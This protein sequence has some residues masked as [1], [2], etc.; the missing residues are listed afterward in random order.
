MA[1][2][3]GSGFDGK[4][5]LRSG[6]Y[7]TLIS[8]FAVAAVVVINLIVNSLPSNLTKPDTTS[9]DLYTLGE[10]TVSL[11]K[12]I[13]TDVKLYHLVQPNDDNLYV[14][15][16]SGL[17]ERYEGLSSRISVERVDPAL[18]P[19]FASAYTDDSVG[20][21][22]VIAV[23]SKRSKVV[24]LSD[25]YDVEQ[26]IDYSTYQY[27]QDVT[28]FKGENAISTAIDYVTTDVL[29][30]VYFLR[31]HN[32]VEMDESFLKYIDEEN[33]ARDTIS[34]IG[35]ES[36]PDDCDCIAVNAP[37]TDITE[38]EK[39]LL[40][41]WLSSGG[42]LMVMTSYGVDT[43]NLFALLRHYGAELAGGLVCDPTAYRYYQ[44]PY[45]LLPI[46][47]TS[48]EMTS[49][50]GQLTFFAPFCDGIV[51]TSDSRGEVDYRALLYTST[52]AYAKVSPK[53]TLEKEEGDVPGPC[54]VAVSMEEEVEN[55]TTKIVWIST[56]Q[57][58]TYNADVMCAGAN[59]ALFLNA[60]G[61]MCDKAS[62]ISIHSKTLSVDLLTVT[63]TSST[64]WGVVLIFLIPA[65]V[66]GIGV[67]VWI[68]RR[69]G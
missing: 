25:M 4:K 5:L 52:G 24:P 26:K 61:W 58:M 32:E 30:K 66:I 18:H 59:S 22:S 45:Y 9:A 33:V 54:N 8:L 13:D 64:I 37:Q 57:M 49:P 35:A 56:D 6:G 19:N 42:H 69:K 47:S 40:L 43:P 50:L 60:L 39:T 1:E 63:S 10:D 21:G 7:A 17:L 51:Q 3:N 15:Y 34:L 68:K 46:V 38:T 20:E 65:L 12:E 29:P 27:T 62:S 16:V 67:F 31:G 23:S 28:G 14:T 48:T 11:L 41:D 44:M 53:D 36:I 2:K 55:G